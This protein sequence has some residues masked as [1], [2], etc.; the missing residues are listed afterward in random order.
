MVFSFGISSF[1]L[2]TFAFWHCSHEE[3]YDIIN[4]STNAVQ[5]SM[6]NIF[7]NYQQCATQKRYS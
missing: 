2:E 4:G 6:N 5:H 1:V 3:S 7:R